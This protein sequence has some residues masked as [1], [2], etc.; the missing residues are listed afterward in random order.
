M[1]AQC[2]DIDRYTFNIVGG[3]GKFQR[4]SDAYYQLW[5]PKIASG[6]SVQTYPDGTYQRGFWD[7]DF[8]KQ[9][10]QD[11]NTVYFGLISITKGMRYSRGGTDAFSGSSKSAIIHSATFTKAS[12]GINLFN[13]VTTL[14]CQT[15]PQLTRQGRIKCAGNNVALPDWARI[16]NYSSNQNTVGAGRQYIQ[17][18]MVAQIEGL[19]GKYWVTKTVS[20]PNAGPLD[21]YNPDATSYD[22]T[23][24]SAYYDAQMSG[25]LGLPANHKTWGNHTDQTFLFDE[26]GVLS[27]ASNLTGKTI[28]YSYSG[29]FLPG[30][31]TVYLSDPA[32]TD[33][34]STI[35]ATVFTGSGDV[36]L[37]Q[38]VDVGKC[39]YLSGMIADR[40]CVP[41]VT[42]FNSYLRAYEKLISE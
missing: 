8:N 25:M 11:Q 42:E 38:D 40:Q 17:V 5:F 24:E 39:V 27:K 1:I 16:R 9:S 22:A 6:T 29:I 15:G 20:G 34:D 26:N 36:Y 4:F 30:S 12:L 32:T 7:K 31:V 21:C 23:A 18:G 3:H 13:G 35:A 10:A 41:S 14:T 28:T 33:N 2:L 37:K 19:P